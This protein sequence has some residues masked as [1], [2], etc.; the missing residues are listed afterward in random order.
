MIPEEL[1]IENYSL[2]VKKTGKKD[3]F[4]ALNEVEKYFKIFT[5]ENYLQEKN[6]T[7]TQKKKF[8]KNRSAFDVSFLHTRNSLGSLVSLDSKI[9]YLNEIINSPLKSFSESNE[10]VEAIVKQARKIKDQL[11]KEKRKEEKAIKKN[12][13]ELSKAITGLMGYKVSFLN[14]PKYDIKSEKFVKEFTIKTKNVPS[15]MDLNSNINTLSNKMEEENKKKEKVFNAK[16]NSNEMEFKSLNDMLTEI[17]KGLSSA[18]LEKRTKSEIKEEVKNIRR[19]KP[20]LISISRANLEKLKQSEMLEID[21]EKLSE[22]FADKNISSTTAKIQKGLESLKQK[23]EIARKNIEIKKKETSDVQGN[24]DSAIKEA[25]LATESYKKVIDKSKISDTLASS[26]ERVNS[27]IEKQRQEL[28]GERDRLVSQQGLHVTGQVIQG[29]EVRNTYSNIDNFEKIGGL[30]SQI[31]RKEDEM[32]RNQVKMEEERKASLNRTIS[33]PDRFKD[34][35]R[36]LEEKS[37]LKE[38][39]KQLKKYDGGLAL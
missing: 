18:V 27:E 14:D 33:I 5:I 25:S 16:S 13:K 20:K 4:Q 31:Y 6:R 17:D 34:M 3:I 30:S 1:K 37:K 8:K 38:A 24:I 19:T 36:K 11:S 35:K 10:D 21:L 9:S 2:F 7:E 26:T 39:S 15:I 29:G 23:I 22:S 12:I 32:S 28:L